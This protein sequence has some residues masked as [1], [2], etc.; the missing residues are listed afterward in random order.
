MS[1]WFQQYT[2]PYQEINERQRKKRTNE[3]EKRMY[4]KHIFQAEKNPNKTNGLKKWQQSANWR[5]AHYW[6]YIKCM[7]TFATLSTA[8]TT[9][10]WNHNE[11]KMANIKHIKRNERTKKSYIIV[12]R[13]YAFMSLVPFGDKNYI[14][15]LSHSYTSWAHSAYLFVFFLSFLIFAIA[16]FIIY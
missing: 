3:T 8:K 1:S 9:P 5:N 10:S 7:R 11:W 13:L 16:V 15:S 2:A 14:F 6:S 4:E 12:I